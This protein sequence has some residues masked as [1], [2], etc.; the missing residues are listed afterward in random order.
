MGVVLALLT[1]GFLVATRRA[2]ARAEAA[3]TRRCNGDA[4]LCSA[5]LDQVTFPG[6]H[7]SMSASLYPGWLFGEQI[8]TIK[9]QLDA[10][11]RAFLFDT[12][13]GAATNVSVPGTNA[14]LVVTDR[15]AELSAPPGSEVDID[16]ATE[17]RAPALRQRAP[18]RADAQRQIFLC[19]NYCELG[20]VRF[21]SVL[22]DVGTSS[23]ATPT[24]SSSSSSRTPR[25]WPTRWPPSSRRA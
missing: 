8:P 6:T 2:D 22:A 1:G 17:Q 24:T 7:N 3:G 19:H 25:P 20:A 15:A 12:H 9:A 21:S 13:Y 23:T 11:V 5:R 16:P 14:P 4:E 10:G 18:Q